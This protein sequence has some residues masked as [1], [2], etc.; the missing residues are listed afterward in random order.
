M[1]AKQDQQMYVIDSP[2]T[3]KLR[4]V[5]LLAQSHTAWDLAQLRLECKFDFRA[6]ALSPWLHA[7]CTL[8]AKDPITLW[9]D[10]L[11]L[12]CPLVLVRKVY[13]YLVSKY[14]ESDLRKKKQGNTV[15]TEQ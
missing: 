8:P 9:E 12:G 2:F 1:F 13:V 3:S 6:C 5:K 4:E 11:Y 15:S 14:L 7:S 10:S